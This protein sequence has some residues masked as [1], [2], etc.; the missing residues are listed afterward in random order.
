MSKYENLVG[1]PYVAGRQDCFSVIRDYYQQNFGIRFKNY[2]RPDRFWEDPALDL[3]QLFGREGGVM[4][5]DN[6]VQTGDVLLIP[7]MT[8]IAAHAAVVVGDNLMLHHPPGGLSCVEPLRPRWLSRAAMVLRHP[9]VVSDDYIQTVHL[10]EVTD[11]PIFRTPEYKQTV[12]KL[13]GAGG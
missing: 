1:H 10:H 4:V 6:S 7:L 3:Y 12:A 13:L 11:A 8:R 2:A 5:H 9:A